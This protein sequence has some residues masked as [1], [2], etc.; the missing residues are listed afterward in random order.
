MAV[1]NATFLEIT[2]GL[3]DHFLLLFSAHLGIE[4]KQFAVCVL[5]LG[6]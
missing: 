2:T 4:P 6:L 5:C 3:Y 1:L